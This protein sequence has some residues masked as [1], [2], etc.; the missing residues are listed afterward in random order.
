MLT[1]S[2]HEN[3]EVT[4]GKSKR[5]L[6]EIREIFINHKSFHKRLSNNKSIFDEIFDKKF[7]K[8]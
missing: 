1:S 6:N 2:H 7:A 3:Y 5:K 8:Q 4:L